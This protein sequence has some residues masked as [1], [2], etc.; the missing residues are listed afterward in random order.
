MGAPMQVEP[1]NLIDILEHA[2]RIHSDGEVVSRLIEDS[3]IHRT[4]YGEILPRTKQLANALK[5]LG[6]D[7]GDRVATLAWNGYRHVESWFAIFGQGAVYHTL[8]PRLHPDQLIYIINHAEDRFLLTDLSF[9]PILEKIAKDL[10]T[11]EGYIIM[12]DRAHMPDTSLENVHCYEE[13]LAAE[14]AEFDWPR[15]PED[16]PCGLCYTSG[17]TGNPK[18][19]MYTHRSIYLHSLAVNSKDCIGLS[20]NSSALVVVPMF[21]ANA[22]GMIQAAPMC[23]AKM[24]L[25]GA[26]M[27]GK[28]IYELIDGEQANLSAAVPTVWTM[29]LDYMEKENKTIECMEEVIIGGSA[30]PR[31]MIDIFGRKYGVDVLHAWGM[32]EMNPLGTV[33]RQKAFMKKLSA[34]E[35]LDYKCK[36]GYPPFGVQMKIIDD[37][38]NE[39]PRDGVAF[40]RLMVKGPWVVETYYKFDEPAV[41]ADGWF[42]TGD[43]ATLD[44]HGMMEI[45]D[46]AK[47]V[48]K[49]GGEWISSVILEN[50]AV[51]H[52]GIT[53]AA[54][55]GIAHPKWEERPLLIVVP[56]D[57][58]VLEKA[59]IIEF[60]SDKV[61][62]W[63]LPDDV[64]FVE[65]IPLTASG[66][67]SKLNLRKQ[68]VDYKFPD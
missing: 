8:N 41:D 43:V 42:D 21:H 20:P 13:L 45:T 48:I 32:T 61:A 52:P 56:K 33:N 51:G 46:R 1:V 24:I 4:T 60:M 31:S 59:E 18:G 12:T 2:A 14:T 3:S 50:E 5:N 53:I 64:V 29:L 16:T 36:Q 65:E 49:S 68:F 55:I 66:K 7:K 25:P 38:D 63:W 23:G 30:A 35:Q 57:G 34:E 47:D 54:V 58:A 67:I 37:D 9:V 27:D 6:V 26:G 11:I 44:S 19:V 22:W 17:T 39:L 10:P 28:S 40:G 62:K 15:F